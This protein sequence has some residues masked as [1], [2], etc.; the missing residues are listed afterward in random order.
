MCQEF[1]IICLPREELNRLQAGDINSLS[2][3]AHNLKGLSMNFN[4]NPL[5]SLAVKLEACGSQENLADVSALVEQIEKEAIRLQEYLEQ[6][7]K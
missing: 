1:R 5:S 3:F 6:L 2:R 4:A 7:L